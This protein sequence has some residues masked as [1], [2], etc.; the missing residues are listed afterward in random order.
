IQGTG[1]CRRLK[2]V[3]FAGCS[4][5]EDSS[6]ISLVKCWENY[7]FPEDDEESTL[8]TI[9]SVHSV[10]MTES[11]LLNMLIGI[12]KRKFKSSPQDDSEE[13]YLAVPYVK[14]SEIPEVSGLT[15]LNLSG[16]SKL[17]DKCIEE[18]TKMKDYVVNLQCLDLSGCYRFTARTLNIFVK[19]CPNLSPEHLFYCDHIK[20]G[21][22]SNE[23]SGCCNLQSSKRSC[24][25]PR[26]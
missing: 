22:Y 20:G 23:A 7:S 26:E 12:T 25:V 5:I 18:L 14:N 1:S 2:K 6:I 9:V 21:P 8:Q 13:N 19:C 15:S 24:C 17:S 3:S 11:D 10:T 4:N 16:C